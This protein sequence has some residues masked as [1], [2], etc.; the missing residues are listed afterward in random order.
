MRPREAAGHIGERRTVNVVGATER[1]IAPDSIQ[2]RLAPRG[3]YAPER[4]AEHPCIQTQWRGKLDDR[5]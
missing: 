3:V 2:L 1:V 4:F 5:G